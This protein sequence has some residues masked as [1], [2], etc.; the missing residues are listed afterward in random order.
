MNDK[1]N[2][3]LEKNNDLVV[4]DVKDVIKVFNKRKWWFVVTFIIVLILSLLFSFSLYKNSYYGV[5]SQITI[6]LKNNNSQVM[7]SELYPEESDILW[8]NLAEENIPSYLGDIVGGTNREIFINELNKS[9][10]FGL[11]DNELRE[12]IGYTIDDKENRLTITTYS[13][14]METAKKIN[15]SLINIY[16][17]NRISYF[18]TTYNVLLLKVEKKISEN[19]LS[20]N[21]E[22]YNTLVSIQ[23]DL[24]ENKDIYI[25]RITVANLPDVER[26][27][28]NLTDVLTGIFISVF[29]GIVVVFF[30]NF[31][32]VKRKK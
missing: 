15:E 12:R 21:T 31:I 25:N 17:N 27:F 10:N 14:D 22:E 9:L 28:F 19:Q 29:A 20:K 23:K 1:N 32:Y 30:I 3:S 2:S 13:D 11:S 26:I 16:T 24:V 6:T 7:I 8:L 4:L 18:N 5:K